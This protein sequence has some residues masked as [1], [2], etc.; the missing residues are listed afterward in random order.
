MLR[1]VLREVHECM[2]RYL[3]NSKTL[4]IM[5][6]TLLV[7]YFF[8]NNM[9]V[10]AFLLVL[11][12]LIE[13]RSMIRAQKRIKHYSAMLHMKQNIITNRYCKTLL[14]DQTLQP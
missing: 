10:Q 11:D 4:K 2:P 6:Q 9:N 7:M 12:I 14:H 3:E 8:F 13:E 1:H 5:S